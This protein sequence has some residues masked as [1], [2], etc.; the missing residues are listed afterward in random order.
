MSSTRFNATGAPNARYLRRPQNPAINA[1][2]Q[3][4]RQGVQLTAEWRLAMLTD[5]RPEAPC[6]PAMTD[7]AMP[8][9]PARDFVDTARYYARLGFAEEWH[10]GTLLRLIQ[11]QGSAATS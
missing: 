7:H 11:N 10:D 4:A 6:E 9:L 3:T 1:R 5:D 2:P 8:I